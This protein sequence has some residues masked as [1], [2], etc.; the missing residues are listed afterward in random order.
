MPADAA[1]QLQASV[2]KTS[3]FHGSWVQLPGGTA[4]RGMFARVIYSATANNADGSTTF[5][6]S[7]DTSPDNGSTVYSGDFVSVE[8]NVT[9]NSATAKS[10]EFY[11]PINV[12]QVNDYIR[13]SLTISGAGTLPTTTYQVD[14]VPARIQ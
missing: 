6:W 9:M 2:T 14:I 11:I 1:L 8:N 4:R 12:G 13:A 3:T 5:A 10:G 7:I